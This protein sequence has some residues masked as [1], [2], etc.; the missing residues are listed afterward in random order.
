M[1]ARAA[2]CE[3]SS[4]CPEMGKFSTARWVCA[5]H[6]AL[7]GTRTSPIESCSMRNSLSVVSVIG[8]GPSSYGRRWWY[9]PPTGLV[10]YGDPVTLQPPEDP[11][12]HVLASDAERE[13]TVESLR[14]AHADGRLTFE[15]LSDRSELAYRSRTAA[16]LSLLTR[17]LPGGSQAAPAAWTVVTGDDEV[18]EKYV[19]VFSG[20]E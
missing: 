1:R 9:E 10:R 17:D 11:Y 2:M 5:R 12:G 16:E 18:T 7:A 8:C 13:A 15:E 4:V 6:L 20:S 3:R 19:A 14:V